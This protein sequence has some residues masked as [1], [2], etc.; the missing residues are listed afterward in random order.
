MQQTR[1]TNERTNERNKREQRKNN[2]KILNSYN[3]K[4][5]N[6]R[7]IFKKKKLKNKRTKKRKRKRKQT[8]RYLKVWSDRSIGLA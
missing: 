2:A 5:N 1:T 6:D 7:F 4:E 8:T 3:I